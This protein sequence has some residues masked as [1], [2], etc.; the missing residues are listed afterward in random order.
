MFGHVLSCSRLRP[1][2]S[3]QIYEIQLTAALVAALMIQLLK[4]QRLSTIQP[5]RTRYNYRPQGLCNQRNAFNRNI[6]A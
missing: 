1:L 3:I 5:V 6:N 4:H 2:P